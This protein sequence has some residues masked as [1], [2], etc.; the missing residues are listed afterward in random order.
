[1]TWPSIKVGVSRKMMDRNSIVQ[2]MVHRFGV[3]FFTPR[4]ERALGL[5]AQ[6]S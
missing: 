6:S 1:M 5:V 4:V 2:K 3:C